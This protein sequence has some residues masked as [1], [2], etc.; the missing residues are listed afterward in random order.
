MANKSKSIINIRLTGLKNET[1]VQFHESVI[2]LGTTLEPSNLPFEQLFV[3]YKQ[4][5]DH[6]TEALLLITKSELTGT[7]SE[8]DGK[9]DN[10]FRGFIDTIKGF[11]NHYETDKRVAANRLWNGVLSHYGNVTKKTMD[12]ETAAIKDIIR[13]LKRP[14]MVT[15]INKLNIQGWV[16]K[17]EQENDK[18]HSLMMER[19][20]EATEKTTYRMRTTRVETDKFYRAIVA[21]IENEVL[22]EN[23]SAT[24][25]HFITELNAIVHRYK[26]ILAHEQGSKKAE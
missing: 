22:L 11:R 8:Q 16:T 25:T 26:S 14:E 4:T 1:H 23:V 12:A 6:E 20:C 10:M 17:L 9:R 24:L 2:S 18:F 15:A 19:Y 7:I 21:S 3:R 13:E 5:F